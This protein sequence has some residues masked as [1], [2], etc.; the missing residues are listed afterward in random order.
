MSW[1]LFAFGGASVSDLVTVGGFAERDSRSRLDNRAEAFITMGL[2]MVALWWIAHPFG[3]LQE[4]RAA[5]AIAISIVTL[6]GVWCIFISPWWHGDTLSSWGLGDPRQ[7][8][9]R[10]CQAYQRRETRWLVLFLA[11]NL[12]VLVLFLFNF[13]S[14]VAFAAKSRQAACMA[15]FTTP[16]GWIVRVIACCLLAMLVTFAVMRYDNLRHAW[17]PAVVG[18]AVLGTIEAVATCLWPSSKGLR[19]D[20]WLLAMIGYIAWG[21]LQ[22]LLFCGYF[23]NRLR[24]GFAPAANAAWA[25]SKRL[26]VALL[27]GLFFGIIHIPSWNL[28]LFTIVLG[29]YLSWFFMDDRY[30]NLLVLSLIHAV[31]GSIA[32]IFFYGSVEM[33]VGPWNADNMGIWW[34]GN[35]ITAAIS[36]AVLAIGVAIALKARSRKTEPDREGVVFYYVFAVIA[37]LVC[38]HHDLFFSVA[39]RISG[40]LEHSRASNMVAE[41]R[42]LGLRGYHDFA[43]LATDSSPAVL[44]VEADTRWGMTLLYVMFRIYSMPVVNAWLWMLLIVSAANALALLL[45]LRQQGVSA[46]W[47]LLLTLAALGFSGAAVSLADIPS[48]PLFPAFACFFCVCR[49]ADSHSRRYLAWAALWL[50]TLYAFTPDFAWQ[51]AGVAA[52]AVVVHGSGQSCRQWLGKHRAIAHAAAA[53]VCALL[54][55]PATRE[56]SAS[57]PLSRLGANILVEHNGAAEANRL[58]LWATPSQTRPL[59]YRGDL[60]SI[61]STAATTRSFVGDGRLDRNMRARVAIAS[62]KETLTIRSGERVVTGIFIGEPSVI[63][64]GRPIQLRIY[65]ANESKKSWPDK[66]RDTANPVLLG[67]HWYRAHERTHPLGESRVHIPYALHPGEIACVDGHAAIVSYKRQPLPPGRYRLELG[68]LQEGI[69]W[70]KPSRDNYDEIAVIVK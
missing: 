49:Y 34:E 17:R 57:Q 28:V 43:P 3:V 26:A 27:S 35:I 53:L 7:V 63:Q 32:R 33:S 9:R 20:R 54:V 15:F 4:S 62:P 1:N 37:C 24:K 64:Q 45:C 23:G 31:L 39:Q 60:R 48:L 29:T 38:L 18:I 44:A 25:G 65:I 47:A 36:L 56:F 2:I 40:H 14:M 16:F 6:V 12:L 13:P 66:N 59:R 70:L 55:L 46:L 68:I 67:I 41:Y 51:S 30:R 22:Q 50:I 69:V 52:A 5:S 58:L 42:Y 19:D 8:W 10:L 11:F 61:D 21:T